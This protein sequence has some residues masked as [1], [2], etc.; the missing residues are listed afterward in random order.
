[1]KYDSIICHYAEIGLKGK[2]RKFFEE[3]LME[4]IKKSFILN[5]CD[6]IKNIKRIS[7]RILIKIDDRI[8]E[9]KATQALKNVFG[10]AYFSFAVSCEQEMKIIKKKA[11]ELLKSKRFKTFRI[12]TKRSEKDFPLTSQEV[13][14]KVGEYVLRKSKVKSQKSKINVNLEKPDVT[15]FI[16]I[17]E[18]YVFLYL[19]KIKGQGG[20]PIG[21]SGKAISLLSGGIDSPVASFYGMRRGIRMIFLHFQVLS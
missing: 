21:V 20:L 8:K 12:E 7:G 16:E 18:K 11:V 9:D 3:G 15:C 14:E 6:G 13:N 19:E 5:S 2:N 17:V 1:M 4:N 10:V